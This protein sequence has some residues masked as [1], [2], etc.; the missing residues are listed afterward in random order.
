MSIFVSLPLLLGFLPLAA[1]AASAVP[2]VAKPSLAG[3]RPGAA[4]ANGNY[5]VLFHGNVDSQGKADQL[6]RTE[7]VHSRHRFSKAVKGLSAPLTPAQVSKLRTDPDVVLV[8]PDLPVHATADVA[9]TPGD[10]AP[11]GVR[12]IES[13]TASTVR[14]AST[15]NVAV[16][17]TGIDLTNHDL[18]VTPG[19]DC[20]GSASGTPQDDN[21]HGTH[22]AGTIAGNNDRSG[23]VGAAPG[24]HEYAVKV[25]D[26]AGGGSDSTIMCGID[27]ATATRSDSDPTNDIAVANLSLGGVGAP[28]GP[29]GTPTTEPLHQAICD[30]TAAGVT[31]VVAAGNSGYDFDYAPS[32]DTPAAYPEVLTVTAVSDG[33]GKP[34]G[35]GADPACSDGAGAGDDTAAWFSNYAA[36]TEGSAHTIA[37][38]GVCITSD[39]PGGGTA[40]MSGTSMATPH[41]TGAVALCLGEAGVAGPCSGLSP[42]QIITTMRTTAADHTAAVPSYGFAGDPAQASVGP[43]YGYLDWSGAAASAPAAPTGASATAG[44]SNVTLRWKAPDSDGRSPLTGYSVT[45]Y[46][47]GSPQPSRTFNSVATSQQINGLTNGASYT[48]TVAATNAIG[49]GPSSAP[50]IAVTPSDPVAAYYAKLG[51]ASSY[52]GAASGAESSTPGGGLAQDYRGGSIYWSPRTAAHAVHGAILVKYKA[53]GG[54]GSALGYPVSDETTTPGGVGR[55]NHFAG[56][57]GSSIYW[58]PNTGAHAIQGA[59]RARWAALGWERGR[60]GFPI[61]DEYAISGG[62][63]NDFVHGFISWKPSTGAVPTYR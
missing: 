43:Y 45:P 22:V 4:S 59:I 50:S 24:T 29:C 9:L 31:Y 37:G 10:T 5:I 8:A 39:A 25:L 41:L 53:L 63:R 3:G 17:D 47:G 15:A 36:T 55:Y 62:R 58:S 19:V 44:N 18:N 28:L 38:P 23:V 51:G 30:S 35:V 56:T 26:S 16:L 12:R 57:G 49:S 13:A 40:V 46:S 61:S 27:W 42:A 52:L 32:P 33:D 54:P 6:A 34:G 7:G 60:L 11:T 48:F 21:G 20:T 2:S 1:G 14:Q